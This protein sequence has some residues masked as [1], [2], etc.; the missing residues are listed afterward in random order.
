MS[1]LRLDAKLNVYFLLEPALLIV[2]FV[3]GN[4]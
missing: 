2:Q 4:I 3:A 1:S